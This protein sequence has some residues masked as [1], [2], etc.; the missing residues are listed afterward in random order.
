MQP[1]SRAVPVVVPVPV[2]HRQEEEKEEEEEDEGVPIGVYS[3]SMPIKVPLVD[4]SALDLRTL[5]KRA[6]AQQACGR[7]VSPRLGL[8]EGDALPD[9]PLAQS[10][11]VP[12]SLS[13][14]TPFMQD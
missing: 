6:F 11:A 9:M 3:T 2:L 12:S 1:P 4:A 8:G 7:A 5:A 14:R 13:F 10:F